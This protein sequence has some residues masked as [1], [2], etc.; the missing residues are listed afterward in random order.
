GGL[1]EPELF[2][3]RGGVFI[4][5]RDGAF[6]EVSGGTL[7]LDEVSEM[8][9]EAQSKLRLV[10]ETSKVRP[11][12]LTTEVPVDARVIA[13]TSRP[14]QPLIDGGV[15]RR[16]LFYCLNIIPIEVPP[17]RDRPED[18]PDLVRMFLARAGRQV[19]LTEPAMQ[20]LSS[21]SW[22]GNVRQLA[23]VIERTV[24]LSDRETVNVEDLHVPEQAPV[25]DIVE[26]GLFA[27]AER[28]VSLDQLERAYIRQVIGAVS[29]NMSEAAR[30]LRID[31]RT[32]YRK[33]GGDT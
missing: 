7:V 27:A 30:I 29:G 19:T 25:D 2:G 23:T 16:D 13:T 20:W 8:T 21:Q 32:L 24:A 18:I 12:G 22:P 10:L 5:A 6:V 28:Q 3:A 14:L 26:R 17:L 31:R 15:F 9:F 1:I 11:L 4:D 33:I